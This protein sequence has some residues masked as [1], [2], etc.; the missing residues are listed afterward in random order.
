MTTT[1]DDMML[2]DDPDRTAADVNGY[3]IAG[4][5]STAKPRHLNPVPGPDPDDEAEMNGNRKSPSHGMILR[6]MLNEH[7]TLVRSEDGRMYGT[8]KTEP[9]K[10]LPH[11]Q[12]DSPLVRAVCMMFLEK[13]GRWPSTTGVSECMAYTR[14]MFDTTTAAPIPLRSHWDRS[15]RTFYIDT[16]DTRNTVLRVNRHGIRSCIS[17][18]AFRRPPTLQALTAAPGDGGPAD[19][20]GL[21][22][23]VPVT[24]EDR[25]IVLALLVTT[26]MTDTPQ[27]ITLFTGHQD[28]GKTST[29]RYLLSY[30]DPTSIKRGR[31]LPAD[32]KEWKAAVSATRV[33][34]VDNLSGL[35]AEASDLLCQVSTGGEAS[36]RKLHTDDDVHISNLHV[37]VWLTA[38]DP[39]ALRGDLA[40]R[41]VKVEL[42]PLTEATRLAESDL[43]VAQDEIRPTVTRGLLWLAHQVMAR[44]DDTD[45]TN[46]GHRMGDF[47]TALRIIDGILGTTGE[48]RLAADSRDLAADVI[49]GSVLGQAVLALFERD[50]HTGGILCPP[51]KVSGAVM[52]ELLQRVVS[53]ADEPWQ[54][55]GGSK[56]LPKTPGVLSAQLK[57]IAPAL[58]L[59]HGIT[60]DHGKSNG[61]RWI[62]ITRDAD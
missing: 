32:L 19:F 59:A 49:E 25:P 41:M 35:N 55:A 40:S 29:A 34:L 36:A 23:I 58:K 4:A 9:S 53:R 57:R 43:A 42:N 54:I 28:S 60:Y 38:I 39:G 12:K 27:P 26:W 21:W 31:T 3:D 13:K 56:S 22:D 51:G 20:D 1:Y 8:R 18:V 33:V 48:K 5:T 44:W 62:Q 7:F 14:A 45:R 61:S 46:L 50:P 15:A 11:D 6:G 37:P 2:P 17:P 30:V 10:A 47:A 52:L 16:C 24:A